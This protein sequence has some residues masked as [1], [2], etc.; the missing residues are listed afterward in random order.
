MDFELNEVQQAFRD[1]IRAF[2]ARELPQAL[3]NQWENEATFPADAY[4]KMAQAGWTGVAIPTEFGG[5][6]GDALDVCVLAEE[7]GKVGYDFSAGFGLTIF[8]ALNLVR[9][10]SEEQKQR[11]LPPVLSGEQRFSIC[12]TEP[13]S[14][15]DAAS[16]STRAVSDGNGGYRL[17]GQ[18]LWA[19]GGHVPGTILMVAC[20]TATRERRQDGISVFL[21]DNAA[22]NV[23]IERLPAMGRNMGGTNIVFLDDVPVSSA[24]LMGPLDGGW[25]VIKSGL[26]LE[27]LYVS[28]AYVGAAQTVVDETLQYAGEREQFGRPIGDFQVIA[29]M[30]ADMQTAV[31]A[32]RLLVY[33]AAWLLKENR[34]CLR[35]VCEAKLLGS[36]TF[37]EVAGKGMQILG[38]HGYMKEASMQRHFADARSTTITAGTSQIQRTL[39]ARDLGVGSKRT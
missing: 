22:P 29:H 27:R 19:T 21:V 4:K 17:R 38:G 9:H 23:T 10:G 1:A 26:L 24:D 37:L 31:D 18:K 8:S 20:R 34:P 13:E 11:L 3:V 36:E 15:S 12:I 14:G 32:S 7:L 6:G 5:G 25:D 39:I 35:E 33:R 16:L 30:L 28:A 2:V